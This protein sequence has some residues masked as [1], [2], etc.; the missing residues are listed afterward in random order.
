MQVGR[1]LRRS[2][3]VAQGFV[4]Y[5]F[6]KPQ[7]EK[8]LHSLSGQLIPM[9]NSSHDEEVFPYIQSDPLL[10]ST[11]ACCLSSMSHTEKPASVF[12]MTYP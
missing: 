11:H 12:W 7:N 1:H 8:R 4:H 5:A 6:E 10:L 9:L 2:D 3:R